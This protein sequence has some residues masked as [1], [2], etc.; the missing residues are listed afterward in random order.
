MKGDPIINVDDTNAAGDELY[1]DSRA[2]GELAPYTLEMDLE[3]LNE[4]LT[5][6]FYE[7]SENGSSLGQLAMGAKKVLKN[8]DEG[9][10]LTLYSLAKT[11]GL[12]NIEGYPTL[13]GIGLKYQV[14]TDEGGRKQV[15]IQIPDRKDFKFPNTNTR[16]KPEAVKHLSIDD[17]KTY[18]GVEVTVEDVPDN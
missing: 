12:D 14:T 1:A 5:D 6:D 2:Y 17:I 16:V 7:M 3:T 13:G 18:P 15:Y 9:L 8:K 4:N 10:A 11:E